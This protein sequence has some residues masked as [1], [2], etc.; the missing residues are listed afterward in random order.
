MKNTH[1]KAGHYWARPLRSV[2]IVVKG[3]LQ[4]V[5][6]TETYCDTLCVLTFGEE[7]SGELREFHFIK[8][9]A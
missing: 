1:I 7:F 9:L 8:K 3:E 6:V 2:G 5:R 4:L